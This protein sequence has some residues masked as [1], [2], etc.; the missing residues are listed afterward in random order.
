[1][2]AADGERS[3]KDSGRIKLTDERIGYIFAII[4]AALFGSV[5]TV[6][7]PIASSI[8][9][10]L[11]SSLVYL[12]ASA[13]LAPVAYRKEIGISSN[14]KKITDRGKDQE[15]YKRNYLFIIAIAIAGGIVAPSL[16]FA[17]L[18]STSATDA[19]L[20]AN[21]EI[22]FTVLIAI[23]FLKEKL[24]LLGYIAILFVFIG[25]FIIT[26][27]LHL[28]SSLF[29]TKNY[30]GDLLILSS[31]IFWAIDNSIS[32]LAIQR[33]G[34]AKAA[35]LKSLI[36]GSVLLLI[37]LAVLGTDSLLNSILSATPRVLF[38]IVLLGTASFGASLYFFLQTIKRLGAVRAILLLSLSSVFGV[39]FAVL[40]LGENVSI[41]QVIAAVIIL[42]GIYLVNRRDAYSTV[43]RESQ[44]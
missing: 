40:F 14:N 1:V 31:T 26:T 41:F 16:Y 23:T 10:L 24:R 2:E 19:T 27:D 28:S 39:I 8:N 42:V 43:A 36:G 12:I 7:K 15:N 29:I 13:I 4:A 5:S 44:L 18:Q 35:Q 6:A 17:G 20:L 3:E 21:G 30:Y 33:I 22:A 34:V 32:K 25:L 38:S 9:P 11:L 37:S